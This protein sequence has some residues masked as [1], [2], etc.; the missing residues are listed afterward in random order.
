MMKLK[1]NKK[2]LKTMSK[3]FGSLKN[4]LKRPTKEIMEDIDEGWN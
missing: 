3:D 2:K 4:V 1:I